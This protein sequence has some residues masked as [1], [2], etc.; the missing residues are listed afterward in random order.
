MRFQ[1]DFIVDFTLKNINQDTWYLLGNKRIPVTRDFPNPE[2]R[3]IKTHIR[4]RVQLILYSD[5]Q[6]GWVCLGQVFPGQPLKDVLTIA[7]VDDRLHRFLSQSSLH[8]LNEMNGEYSLQEYRV[9]IQVSP[10]LLCQTLLPCSSLGRASESFLMQLWDDFYF[11]QE[12]T[13]PEGSWNL[14]NHPFSFKINV[15]KIIKEKIIVSTR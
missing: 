9:T 2:S 14:T 8:R 1:A 4:I 11:S 7:H 6:C 3:E 5:F 12:L 13:H 10:V 15:N